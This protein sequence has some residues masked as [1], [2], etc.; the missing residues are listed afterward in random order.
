[1]CKWC[2]RVHSFKRRLLS[3]QNNGCHFIT[4]LFYIIVLTQGGKRVRVG[5][6]WDSFFIYLFAFYFVSWARLNLPNS[7]IDDQTSICKQMVFKLFCMLFTPVNSKLYACSGGYSVISWMQDACHCI[8]ML[9]CLHEGVFRIILLSVFNSWK[10]IFSSQEL[11]QHVKHSSHSCSPCFCLDCCWL[12]ITQAIK[13]KKNKGRETTHTHIHTEGAIMLQ[14][15]KGGTNEGRRNREN[16][17]RKKHQGETSVTQQTRGLIWWRPTEK[18][19]A[20]FLC[21]CVHSCV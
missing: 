19:A 6:Y 10:C 2:G 18:Q 12:C 8:L 1:M 11:Q 14:K 4:L 9:F 21:E 16:A 13:L 7:N 3:L 20:R 5:A 15:P 17:V